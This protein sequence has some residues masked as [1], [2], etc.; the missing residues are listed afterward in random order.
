MC[1]VEF[2]SRRAVVT[3]T[4]KWPSLSNILSHLT[5]KDGVLDTVRENKV[6]IVI[7]RVLVSECMIGPLYNRHPLDHQHEVS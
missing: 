6:E 2:V 1:V 7:F 4:L 5:R 3:E